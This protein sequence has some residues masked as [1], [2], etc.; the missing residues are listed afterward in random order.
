LENDANRIEAL[1]LIRR[2]RAFR[3]ARRQTLER[4]EDARDLLSGLRRG[5]ARSALEDLC[6]TIAD[7]VA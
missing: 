6:H 4:A 1:R 2:H 3:E 7:R 5:A